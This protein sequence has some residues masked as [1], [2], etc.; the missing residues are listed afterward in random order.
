MYVC[1]TRC[2][3]GFFNMQQV[4]PAGCQPCFCLGHSLACSSS[5]HFAAVTITS[6]FMEG[7]I[8]GLVAINEVRLLLWDCYHPANINKNSYVC[9]Q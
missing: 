2:K 8:K 5:P 1:A 4:N 7:I 6:D 3:P 9:F